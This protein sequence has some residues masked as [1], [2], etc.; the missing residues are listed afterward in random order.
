MITPYTEFLER[1]ERRQRV[2]AAFA[3][4][5]ENR[6][7]QQEPPAAPA[8][9]PAIANDQPPAGAVAADRPLPNPHTDANGFR[10]LERAT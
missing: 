7:E 9:E 3:H 4:P 8:G 1:R 10:T 6:Q 2:K 5:A